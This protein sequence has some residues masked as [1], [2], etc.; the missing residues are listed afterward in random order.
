MDQMAAEWQMVHRLDQINV[1]AWE[2]AEDT[3]I[4]VDY[5]RSTDR[6]LALI[7]PVLAKYLHE[8]LGINDFNASCVKWNTIHL[9]QATSDSIPIMY[10]NVEVTVDVQRRVE[11]HPAY[12]AA[13]VAYKSDR[14]SA[15]LRHQTRQT[16]EFSRQ[17]KVMAT[18]KAE[19]KLKLVRWAEQS[20]AL[21]RKLRAAQLAL[22]NLA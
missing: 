19:S 8:E 17:D 11:A 6:V 9:E 4:A 7:E 10:R 3:T 12:A 2:K 21:A 13:I 20:K 15:G 16:E 5:N 1:Q 22:Q 18:A 14:A